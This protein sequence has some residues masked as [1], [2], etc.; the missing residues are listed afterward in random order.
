MLSTDDYCLHQLFHYRLQNGD[1]SNSSI[2]FEGLFQTLLH[3]LKRTVEK[4]VLDLWCDKCWNQYKHRALGIS[5]DYPFSVCSKD[6][7]V[8]PLGA[9]SSSPLKF[10]H[11]LIHRIPSAENGLFFLWTTY[12]CCCSYVFSI[13]LISHLH[14][15]LLDHKGILKPTTFSTILWRTVVLDENI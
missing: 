14:Y 5:W 4:V 9:T 2:P 11:T 8:Q 12:L 6:S 15:K 3:T 1:F 7:W 10:P 13:T